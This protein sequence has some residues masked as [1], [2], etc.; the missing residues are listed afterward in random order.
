[1]IPHRQQHVGSF[2]S[3]FATAVACALDLDLAQV[4]NFVAFG[5]GRWFEA[6]GLW[7]KAARVH[8]D[9][10]YHDERGR[11]VTDGGKRTKWPRQPIVA[12]GQGPRGF[13][14]AVVYQGGKLRHDPYP[15]DAG[16]VGNPDRYT[17]LRA[18]RCRRCD[19]SAG[20]WKK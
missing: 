16:L 1:M 8:F 5:E 19:Q 17:V 9:F 3:C 14:H 10:L 20:R 12:H 13:R 4:P 15:G 7:C 6:F 11:L 2:G 18:K